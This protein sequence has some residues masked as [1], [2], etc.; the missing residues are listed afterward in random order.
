ESITDTPGGGGDLSAPIFPAKLWRMV[1]NP[2]DG[3][4]RWDI[5]GKVIIIDQ[6]LLETRILS[7]SSITADSFKTTNFTSFVRQL[8]LYGFKK[9][10]PR[11][12]QVKAGEARSYHYY[13]NPNFVRSSPQLLRNL[14][15]LTVG[16]KAKLSAGQRLTSRLPNPQSGFSGEN[17][18]LVLTESKRSH[19]FQ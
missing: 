12:D 6:Q 2:E 5:C 13:S 7:P 16:N 17:K 18:D 1:N 11:V 15:R 3:A 8:N 14:V 4:I 10:Q 9:H 19:L